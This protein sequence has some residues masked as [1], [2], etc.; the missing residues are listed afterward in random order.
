M[1]HRCIV[2]WDDGRK[3]E[4]ERGFSI[5]FVNKESVGADNL[6]VHMS[7]IKPGE[8]AHPPHAHEGEEVMFLLDGT[9][10]AQ[11]GDETHV[12]HA[13]TALFC[14]PNEMH[15][16]RNCGDVPIRYLV[17]RTP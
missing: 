10:E 6:A 9:A 13:N 8:R 12:I 17:I 16:L 15:G 4:H 5:P 2:P 1:S 7:V 3:R 14:P 11:I